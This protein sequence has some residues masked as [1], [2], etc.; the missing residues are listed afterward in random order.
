[1]AK[2]IRDAIRDRGS[3][4][5]A[6]SGGSSPVGAYEQ[7]AKAALDWKNVHVFWVDERAVGPAHERSNYLLVKNAL[8]DTAGIEPANVHRMH[9]EAADLDSAAHDYEA[10]LRK[11]VPHQKGGLPSFDLQVL[12]IGSDGHTASLFPGDPTVHVTDRL[13][14]SVAATGQREARL[15]LTG[16]VLE[17]G[18]ATLVIVL[19]KDKN[20]AISKIWAANGDLNETPG[21]I[22][23]GFRGSIC[24]VIDRPAGGIV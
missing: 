12:G 20:P 22:I 11:F 6:L 21:R 4:A 1:M 10:E 16:P 15:S 18:T 5:I 23:R 9:G 13:V 7:L 17:N 2:A 8:L 14:A 24:W 3:A 19:G